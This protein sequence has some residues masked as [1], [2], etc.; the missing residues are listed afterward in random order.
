L[1]VTRCLLLVPDRTLGSASD[2]EY[3]VT[4]NEKLKAAIVLVPRLKAS[5]M[6]LSIAF[7]PI[8]LL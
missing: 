1:L 7:L 4:S 8:P 2:T 3:P 5:T 6:G